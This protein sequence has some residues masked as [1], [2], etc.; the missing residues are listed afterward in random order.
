MIK[1]SG[2]ARRQFYETEDLFTTKEA[3]GVNDSVDVG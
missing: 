1:E 3:H 2:K